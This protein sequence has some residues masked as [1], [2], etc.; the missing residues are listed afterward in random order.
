[1]RLNVLGVDRVY[2]SKM[3][4]LT[5]DSEVEISCPR[6]AGKGGR[7]DW[8]HIRRGI[9]HRCDGSGHVVINLARYVGALCALRAL[10]RRQRD[11]GADPEALAEIEADGLSVKAGIVAAGA[12]PEALVQEWHARRAARKAAAQKPRKAAKKSGRRRRSRRMSAEQECLAIES[13][14]D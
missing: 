1:V 12:D 8:M 13:A 4:K 14:Q 7:N 2:G 5:I 3:T 6:C 9:C 11:A 10:Y